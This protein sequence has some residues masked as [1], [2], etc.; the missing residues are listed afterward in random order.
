MLVTLVDNQEQ[1]IAYFMDDCPE[2]I[3]LELV[4]VDGCSLAISDF[5]SYRWPNA[6]FIFVTD[7]TFFSDGSIFAHAQNACAYLQRNTP[8]E[9]L[10]AMVE[11]YVGYDAQRVTVATIP[12]REAS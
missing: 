8:P 9:D 4:L 2:I 3:I 5:S 7:T 10:A 1:A 11:H 6:Q 12:D